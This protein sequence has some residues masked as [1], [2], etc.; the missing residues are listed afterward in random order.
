MVH[1]MDDAAVKVGELTM[2]LASRTLRRE[3]SLLEH[4]QRC[5]HRPAAR[6]SPSLTGTDCRKWLHPM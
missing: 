1:S 4:S 6:R 3:I 5:M 2:T